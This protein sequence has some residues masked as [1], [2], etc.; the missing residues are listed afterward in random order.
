MS[1]KSRT[2]RHIDQFRWRSIRRAFDLPE[3]PVDTLLYGAPLVEPP[4]VE[5]LYMPPVA[6]PGDVNDVGIALT[7]IQQA[8]PNVIVELGTG[9]GAFTANLCAVTDA[10]VYTVNALPEQISG[11]ITTF[12]LTDQ[13]IGSVYRDQGYAGRVSQVYADTRNVRYD[14]LLPSGQRIDF[15]V[16]DACHDAEYVLQ[17]FLNVLPHAHQHTRILMHDTHPSMDG[18]LLGS[19]SACLYLRLLGYDVRHIEG[20]WWGLWSAQHARI[21][22]PPAARFVQASESSLRRATASSHVEHVQRFAF[23]ASRYNR[24]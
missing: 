23:M 21:T 18:H 12:A 20:S 9:R 15:A 6:G 16:L 22:H 13:E 24:P 11:R 4:L 7:L 10:H 14:E 8:Q 3:I 1:L 19:Y 2:R 5:G 17:D